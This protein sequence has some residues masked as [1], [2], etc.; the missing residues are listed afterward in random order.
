MMVFDRKTLEFLDSF[1]Q[2]GSALGNSA[3]FT[4]CLLTRRASSTPQKSPR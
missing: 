1:G 2:W 4:I 3:P